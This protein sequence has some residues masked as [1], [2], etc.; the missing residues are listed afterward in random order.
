[1]DISAFSGQNKVTN[2]CQKY[3]LTSY[4]KC[5][6]QYQILINRSGKNKKKYT[7]FQSL[8][9]D[10]TLWPWNQRTIVDSW[11]GT[12]YTLF[13]SLIFSFIMLNYFLQEVINDKIHPI[14]FE[15]NY[16][17]NLWGGGKFCSPEKTISLVTPSFS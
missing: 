4:Y 13:F 12:Y 3:L 9:H 14:T 10:L 1:M 17:Q 6:S 7:K 8:N 5:S 16:P 2:M 11:L 15:M